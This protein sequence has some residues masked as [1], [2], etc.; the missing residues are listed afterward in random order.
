M[1]TPGTRG[2]FALTAGQW[3]T[4][5][6]ALV[7]GVVLLVLTLPPVLDSRDQ[8]AHQGA[9]SCGTPAAAQPHPSC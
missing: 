9:R 5:A 4:L 2:P 7:L 6:L 1:S 3:Q 8:R